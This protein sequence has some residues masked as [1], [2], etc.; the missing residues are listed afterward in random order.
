MTDGET[1]SPKDTLYDDLLFIPESKLELDGKAPNF[2][3]QGIC[4]RLGHVQPWL[5]NSI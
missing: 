2:I 4:N 3:K 5:R 1:V